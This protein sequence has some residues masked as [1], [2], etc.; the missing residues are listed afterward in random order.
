[1]D[2]LYKIGDFCIFCVAFWMLN[3]VMNKN[4]SG[5]RR[6]FEL[7]MSIWIDVVYLDWCCA[8]KSAYF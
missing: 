6:V 5:R 3:S 1:M 7:V 4:V 8:S 2:V